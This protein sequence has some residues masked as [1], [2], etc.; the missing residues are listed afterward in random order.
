MLCYIDRISEGNPDYISQRPYL[1][2]LYFTLIKQFA[3]EATLLTSI[4][5]YLFEFEKPAS[6]GLT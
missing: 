4:G 2:K 3:V 5:E 1:I 6:S